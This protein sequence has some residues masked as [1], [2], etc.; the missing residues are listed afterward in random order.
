MATESLSAEVTGCLPGPAD[1]LAGYLASSPEVFSS[2]WI[3]GFW[4]KTR[5]RSWIR[6][7]TS[8]ALPGQEPSW[9]L[10]GYLFIRTKLHISRFPLVVLFIYNSNNT[11]QISSSL[12]QHSLSNQTSVITDGTVASP[13]ILPLP[14]SRDVISPNPEKFS[15][16]TRFKKHEA[17]LPEILVAVP[18]LPVSQDSDPL[19]PSGILW[20]L[21]A[22]SGTPWHLLASSGTFW[23]P[24]AP[25]GTSGILW[26]PLAPSGTPWH[27][28]A[29]SGILWHPVASSCTPWHP[30]AGLW[31]PYGLGRPACF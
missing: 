24:L 1:P 13:V 17:R 30:L 6:I 29:P 9:Q 16:E 15:G 3:P 31:Q 20:H 8:V 14:N 4:T 23:H 18:R 21:L 11:R 2:Y 27:P 5:H 25:C 26:H 10:P 19:A 7:Q 22:S 28:L 12:L